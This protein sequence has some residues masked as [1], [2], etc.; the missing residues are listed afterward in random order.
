MEE[1][2]HERGDRHADRSAF[3]ESHQPAL[4][5]TAKQDLF[6]Q[7]RDHGEGDQDSCE[8]EGASVGELGAEEDAD[9][10][11][12]REDLLLPRADDVE[13]IVEAQRTQDRGGE[14]PSAGEAKRQDDA[15]IEIEPADRRHGGTRDE[16]DLSRH[17]SETQVQDLE[18]RP[19]GE[20]QEEGETEGQRHFALFRS[21]PQGGG[22][23]RPAR[24]RAVAGRHHGKIVQRFRRSVTLS[25]SRTDRPS[26]R[27]V[28]GSSRVR[29]SPG[30]TTPRSRTSGDPAGSAPCGSQASPSS[31]GSSRSSG[32]SASAL[33][34]GGTA[35]SGG[36]TRRAGP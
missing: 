4:Q 18:E 11:G 24:G 21:V 25:F 5:E 9:R 27:A 35:R 14:S 8:S 29:S 23:K 33:K 34:R 19:D 36:G 12:C 26:T 22:R 6:A 30:V 7:R 32:S 1:G 31:I 15:R 28:T 13:K 3:E 16:Q 17:Q 10:L 2:E 20:V